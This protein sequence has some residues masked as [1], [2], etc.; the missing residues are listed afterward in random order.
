MT[1]VLVMSV[2]AMMALVATLPAV[3]LVTV[4]AP[5][6][7]LANGVGGGGDVNLPWIE[8][9]VKVRFVCWRNRL[10]A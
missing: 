9:T 10:Q 6:A 8:K 3:M 4:V 2:V 1:S 7:V 5:V